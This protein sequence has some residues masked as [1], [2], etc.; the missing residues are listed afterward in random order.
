MLRHHKLLEKIREAK[1]KDFT[2]F[3]ERHIDGLWVS[4]Y[5]L[6]RSCGTDNNLSHVFK[7]IT[8]HLPEIAKCCIPLQLPGKGQNNTWAF[9]T[10]HYD[11]LEEVFTILARRFPKGQTFLEK[12]S[13]Q[14]GL[15]I[16]GEGK[17]PPT[18]ALLLPKPPPLP[19]RPQPKTE[20]T[21]NQPATEKTKAR[22]SVAAY[23]TAPEQPTLGSYGWLKYGERIEPYRKEW[24]HLTDILL[25]EA[26]GDDYKD[27]A[28]NLNQ[29]GIK[30]RGEIWQVKD[31]AQIIKT[32]PIILEKWENQKPE[33]SHQAA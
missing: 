18:D 17:E 30:N 10:S 7:Q 16:N 22:E 11:H 9:P 33:G 13:K 29:N 23:N 21:Y 14:Y 20:E 32:Y 15:G 6:L 27:I 5:D 25:A 28:K 1:A 8:A 2:C 24:R 3:T 19:P 4:F 31:I 26:R 12:P